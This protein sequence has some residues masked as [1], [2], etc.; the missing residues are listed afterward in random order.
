MKQEPQKEN[1]LMNILINIAIPTL[2]LMKFS[3]EK[4][5]GPVMGLIVALA[6]PILYGIYDFT[7]QKKVNLS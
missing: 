7:K 4:H 5:L 3:G 6:F 1:M 2:I